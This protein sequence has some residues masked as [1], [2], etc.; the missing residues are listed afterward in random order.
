MTVDVD[1]FSL[2]ITE[3]ASNLL[4]PTLDIL[5]YATK[6]QTSVGPLIP[7]A[8][9]SYLFSSGTAL[10]RLRRPAA[11]YTAAIQRR[12]GDYRFVTNRM[13]A[14]AEEIAFYDGV[15]REKNYLQRIF[16]SLLGTIRR[17][18][19]FRHAMDILDSVMAKYIATALGWMLLNRAAQVP[20]ASSLPPS[21]P[22]SLL[23]S[24][25]SILSPCLLLAG[26]L[27]ADCR[28]HLDVDRSRL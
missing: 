13:V 27:R 9:A 26:V 21:L 15:G 10:T 5:L 18:S 7:L 23:P 24:F 12:E 14:H 6:L 4:K 20:P 22:P 16:G 11:E 25:P 8:M 28:D 19:R 2:C 3:L 17:G 1:K